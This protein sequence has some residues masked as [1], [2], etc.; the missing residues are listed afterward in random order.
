MLEKTVLDCGLTILSEYRPEL[1]SFALSYSLRSGSRTETPQNNGIHHLIEHMMFKG[2]QRYDLK[3]IA[4]ISDQL[5][6]NLNAFTSKEIT[7]F[8]LKAIDERFELGFGILTDIILNATFPGEE[9][10][11]EINVVLQEI[12]ESEDTPD[13]HAFEIF[14]EQIF[15][16][17]PLGYPISGREDQV[18]LFTQDMAF[19][20]YKKKY[21]PENLVLAAVGNLDHYSLVKEARGYFSGFRAKL[22]AD[23]SF[24][25][26]EMVF[27][28]AVKEKESLKQT[29]VIIGF[30]GIP[31]VSPIRYKFLLMNEILGSGM[32]SRLFQKI[33]EEKGLAYTVHSFL[34]FYLDNGLLIVYSIVEAEKINDYLQSVKEEINL[35]K[36]KGVSKEELSR[37]K[38]HLKSSIILA[39]ESNAAKMSFNVSQDLFLK[40]ELKINE[41]L[42]NIN[43]TTVHDI[44]KLLEIHLNL[45]Q[46]AMLL[47]GNVQK[48]RYQNFTF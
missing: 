36:Q 46:V 19:K 17:N 18:L 1:P 37:A 20:F 15:E 16:N 9:F 33:R 44:N 10:F 40:R 29:Y 13:T 48:E 6:G 7:Q 45:D 31:V 21:N 8:Y 23:F 14:Y 30:K 28:T 3:Q 26:P 41:I 4:R 12:K 22:P 39:L 43:E 5:G 24:K 34:D 38:D 2:S 11:K 42:E 35:L 47:Y 32:S 27:G 25:K